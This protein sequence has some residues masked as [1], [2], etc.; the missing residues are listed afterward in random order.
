MKSQI[1]V[2]GLS[3]LIKDLPLIHST[4]T[5]VGYLS[6]INA[7]ERAQEEVVREMAASFDAPTPFI[8]KSLRLTNK[9]GDPVGLTIKKTDSYGNTKRIKQPDRS[10]HL[11]YVDAYE[12]N[13]HDPVK[14]TMEPEIFGG[15][16]RAKPAELR[17]RRAKILRSNEYLAVARTA[18]KNKYGNIPSAEYIRMLSDL[19][20]FNEGGY[21]ANKNYKTGKGQYFLLSSGS[22]KTIFR[23]YKTRGLVPIWHVVQGA[24]S[25]SRRLDFF[26]TAAKKY[27]QVYPTEFSR[28]FKRRILGIK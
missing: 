23:R 9:F 14:D 13:R 15:S 22:N 8:K 5:D 18:T 26:E 3:E 16:R 7:G 17:L 24:P 28:V 10:V 4:V 20:T 21:T 25:Y 2:I 27:V 19:Q 11:R 12:T 6:S 1:T